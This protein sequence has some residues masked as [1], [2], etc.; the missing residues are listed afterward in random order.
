MSDNEFNAIILG[1]FALSFLI[2]VI[3][4]IASKNKPKKQKEWKNSTKNNFNSISIGSFVCAI[5]QVL[6]GTALGG[7]LGILAFILGIVALK[8]IKSSKERGK[9]MAITAIVLGSVWGIMSFIVQVLLGLG[10][11]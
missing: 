9:G 7:I 1:A 2:F 8:E 11:E 4:D 5:I 10:Y 3:A 6:L